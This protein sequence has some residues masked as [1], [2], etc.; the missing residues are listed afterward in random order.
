MSNGADVHAQDEDGYYG[1]ALQAASID[2]HLETV[3]FLLQNGAEDKKKVGYHGCALDAA[4]CNDKFEVIKLLIAWD[5]KGLYDAAHYNAIF[6]SAAYQ[7]DL[8]TLTYLL[9]FVPDATG[10]GPIGN[11]TALLQAARGG[12]IDIV[13]FLIEKGSPFNT[14]DN[15]TLV[16]AAAGGHTEILKAFLDDGA[17]V[18]ARDADGYFLLWI[19]SFRGHLD[20]VELLIEYGADVNLRYRNWT[21][22]GIARQLNREDIEECILE[23]E[24]YVE[25][26]NPLGELRVWA[27]PQ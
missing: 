6:H 3:G 14:H 18:D 20:T 23:T 16:A 22:V 1:T 7:G 11:G 17:D 9:D 12:H 13:R 10:P 27:E 15:E 8:Q 5:T 26:I 19:A 24:E 21:A 4:Y 25:R 2:G